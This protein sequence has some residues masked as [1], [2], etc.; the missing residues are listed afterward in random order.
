MAS[1]INGQPSQFGKLPVAQANK[2]KEQKV[3]S[4]ITRMPGRKPN[5]VVTVYTLPKNKIGKLCS[6]SYQPMSGK[7]TH[8]QQQAYLMKSRITSLQYADLPPAEK[9]KQ[10][11]G[12][13][14][15]LK[16]INCKLGTEMAAL[17]R[18]SVIITEA[19]A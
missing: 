18:H 9:E 15:Q 5:D 16:Y 11:A 14:C 12:L 7:T 3:S 13:R 17:P 10:L 6:F 2:N 19:D 4:S 1:I 8:L